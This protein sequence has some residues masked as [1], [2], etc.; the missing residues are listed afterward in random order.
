MFVMGIVPQTASE[1]S[2]GAQ[3][4][5]FVGQLQSLVGQWGISW[6]IPSGKHTKNYG[7]IHHV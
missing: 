7:K 2:N 5:I 6:N 3:G 1:A 4:D